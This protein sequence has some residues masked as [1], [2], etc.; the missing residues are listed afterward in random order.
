MTNIPFF[1]QFADASWRNPLLRN[2]LA[3]STA[4]TWENIGLTL[5]LLVVGYLTYVRVR[6]N[7][8]A[9]EFTQYLPDAMKLEEARRLGITYG[10][11]LF[12]WEAPSYDPSIYETMA[13]LGLMVMH[14]ALLHYLI[15]RMII[16]VIPRRKRWWYPVQDEIQILPVSNLQRFVGIVE[17]PIWK[18]SLFGFAGLAMFLLPARVDT[19]LLP[20]EIVDA[21]KLHTNFFLLLVSFCFWAWVFSAYRIVYCFWNRTK[22]KHLNIQLWSWGPTI[23]IC[24]LLFAIEI[25]TG[26]D[27]IDD[28]FRDAPRAML[29]AVV[30]SAL[31]PVCTSIYVSPHILEQKE[32]KEK[33]AKEDKNPQS[34]PPV[35]SL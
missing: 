29:T 32:K 30:L 23:A 12:Y 13:L 31:V 20:D 11:P 24:L 33:M 3:R 27:L 25:E 8:V 18:V 9:M 10:V 6:Y 35:P 5:Y 34:S 28:L 1:S 14:F 17:W 21:T 19:R 26:N 15:L 22:E 16:T 2:R 4:Y 7:I